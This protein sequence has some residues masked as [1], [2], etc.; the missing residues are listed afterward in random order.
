MLYV[1]I[2]VPKIYT[3]NAFALKSV[4]IWDDMDDSWAIFLMNWLNPFM[5]NDYIYKNYPK[6]GRN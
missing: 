4:L 6:C 2:W 5:A 1:H 3:S